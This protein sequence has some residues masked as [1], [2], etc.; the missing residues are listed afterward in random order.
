MKADVTSDA[1]TTY[2]W[3]SH[4]TESYITI[5]SSHIDEEWPLKTSVLQTRAMPES[6]TRVNIAGVITDAVE[7]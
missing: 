5:T 3:T 4:A 6:H 1:L 7:E 2:G